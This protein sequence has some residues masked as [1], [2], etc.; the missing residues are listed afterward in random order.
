MEG[1]GW[2]REEKQGI[3]LGMEAG[4]ERRVKKA[5]ERKRETRGRTGGEEEA[6]GKQE[7]TRAKGKRQA[8]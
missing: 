3:M 1:M 8:T 6:L 7:G 2:A 5:E 4:K